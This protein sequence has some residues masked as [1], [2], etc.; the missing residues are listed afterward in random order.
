M[1]ICEYKYIMHVL[2]P[3]RYEMQHVKC[4]LISR[5]CHF[6]QLHNTLQY[7]TLFAFYINNK[8]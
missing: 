4:I 5:I 1:E 2:M 6:I 3:S 7:N 8:L